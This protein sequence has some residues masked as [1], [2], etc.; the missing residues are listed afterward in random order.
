MPDSDAIKKL[1]NAIQREAHE[2][3]SQLKRYQE[4]TAKM[5]AYQEGRGEAPSMEDF[6]RWR[7]AVDRR[8]QLR[9]F[10]AGVPE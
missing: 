2:Q 6:T 4:L 8:V 1:K 9:R 3:L 7:E 5:M 10:E